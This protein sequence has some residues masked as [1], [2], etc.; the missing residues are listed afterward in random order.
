MTNDLKTTP[1]VAFPV[2]PASAPT[3]TA[4]TDVRITSESTAP[5]PD[6][7]RSSFTLDPSGASPGPAR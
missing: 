5:M 3:D 2:L 6:A 7:T 4:D 1:N